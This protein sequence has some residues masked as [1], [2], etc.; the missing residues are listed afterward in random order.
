MLIYLKKYIG[1]VLSIFE[2]KDIEEEVEA[3]CVCNKT[4]S[5]DDNVPAVVIAEI[6]L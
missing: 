6:E 2:V 1:Y 4:T 5:P 3:V